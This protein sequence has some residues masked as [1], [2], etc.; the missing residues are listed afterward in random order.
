MLRL[1]RLAG[2]AVG[3]GNGNLAGSG[4]TDTH[5][6]G[7]TKRTPTDIALKPERKTDKVLVLLGRVDGATIAELTEVTGWL[8][9][10]ARAMLTGL[11]KKGAQISR[12]KVDGITRYSITVDPASE[13]SEHLQ[14]TVRDS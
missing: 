3:G 5:M 6:A 12:T 2:E 9:H 10:T 7:K 1:D 13:Q 4:S 14:M 11:R 8:P